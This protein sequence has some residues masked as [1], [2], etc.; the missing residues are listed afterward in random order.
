[1]TRSVGAVLCA[2]L[3]G[4]ALMSPSIRLAA[5]SPSALS[6]QL[7]SENAGER[8]AALEEV[9]RLGVGRAS[10]EVRSALIRALQQEAMLH[11]QRDLADRR[12]D[13]LPALDDPELLTR[14]AGTVGEL[15]D[16]ASIPALAA[17]LGSGFAVIRPLAA[18]G[19]RA[20]PAVVAVESSPDSG[21]GA[22]NH[23]LIALRFIVDEANGGLGERTLA[24]LRRVAARR[25]SDGE[26]SATTTLWWAID[27]AWVVKDK[28]LRQL[29]EVLAT[30]P[31][32]VMARGITDPGLIEQ[33]QRRAADRIAGV[34][35]LP[36]P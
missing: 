4:L 21:N 31:N 27:L 20:V 7:L 15:R 17:A 1:M 8:S 32:A 2:C 26:G 30:D 34:P 6:E 25:L 36:R 11:R 5:Q 12:G 28:D 22:I 16:P 10:Q 33:T 29:V 19:E 3:A 35:A 14:L 18:F 9:G 13:N 23:A 24:D